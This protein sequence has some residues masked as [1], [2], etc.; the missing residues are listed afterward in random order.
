[1]NFVALDWLFPAVVK[2]LPAPS[3][4]PPPDLTEMILVLGLRMKLS[5]TVIKK[6]K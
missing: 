1:M 5:L 4:I 2:P 6:Q 3:A